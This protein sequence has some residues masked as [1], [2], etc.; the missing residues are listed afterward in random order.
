MPGNKDRQASQSHL[1]PSGRSCP[2][3]Q[4]ANFTV[5]LSA[6]FVPCVIMFYYF[7]KYPMCFYFSSI[8]HIYTNDFSLHLA[9]YSHQNYRLSGFRF[10][11]F[12]TICSF[13]VFQIRVCF[14]CTVTCA[15]VTACIGD[16]IAAVDFSP[17]LLPDPRQGLLLTDTSMRDSPVSHPTSPQANLRTQRERS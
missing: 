16:H 4:I 6:F 12:L 13:L 5:Y 8:F 10:V 7:I 9:L 2:R 11:F 1:L 14:L 3:W 15:H 17:L